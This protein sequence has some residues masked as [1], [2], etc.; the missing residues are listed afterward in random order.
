MRSPKRK[1]LKALDDFEKATVE[2]F[3]IARKEYPEST[4]LK[5]GGREQK[6]NILKLKSLLRQDSREDMDE[7]NMVFVLTRSTFKME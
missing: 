7:G 5:E 3:Q 1:M 2:A 4:M 6:R